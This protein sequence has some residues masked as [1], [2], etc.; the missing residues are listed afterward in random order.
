M[1]IPRHARVTAIEDL[2]SGTR[3]LHLMAEEPLGFTGGQYIIVDSGLVL[4][5]GKAV[6]RA[7]SMLSQDL[8]QCRFQLAVKRIPDGPG[9]GFMHGLEAGC[10]LRFSGPWGRFFPQNGVNGPVL[11][12]ATDTGITAALGLVRGARFQNLASASTLIWLRT[13][14]GYFLPETFVRD[15]TPSNCADF[16][17]APIP[18]ID[19]PERVAE[20]R[21]CLSEILARVPLAQAFVCGDGAVNY[22]LLDDLVAAGV[23]ATKDHAESFFNMP[24]K[25]A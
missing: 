2:A 24:K 19:L 12:L 5:N 11:V 16:R 22:A 25:S 15:C 4:A 21:A 9:S 18:P 14:P 10:E 7:Y 17:I 20:A 3:L 8:D 1:A 13:R 6:K 23:P